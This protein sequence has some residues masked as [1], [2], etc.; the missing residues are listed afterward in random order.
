VVSEVDGRDFRIECGNDDSEAPVIGF[1]S[2]AKKG[3]RS[4]SQVMIV[5]ELTRRWPKPRAARAGA[6][7][8]D[9]K[10]DNEPGARR[11]PNWKPHT[12]PSR[13]S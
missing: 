6:R 2:T 3:H 1:R 8:A 4:Q 9:N 7:T 11:A 13:N 12:R 5:Q 10:P